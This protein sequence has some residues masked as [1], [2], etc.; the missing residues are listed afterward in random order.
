MSGI[1]IVIP[2]LNEEE[3][4]RELVERLGAALVERVLPYEVIVIDDHSRDATRDVL[5]DISQRYPITVYLKRGQRGKAQSLLEGFAYATHDVVAIL[6]ADLQYPP[7]AIPDMV[8]KLR[9]GYDIV[10]ANRRVYRDFLGRKLVSKI[11]AFFVRT[12]HGFDCDV[13][14]G[15]KVFR[16]KILSEMTLRPT[17]WTFDLEFL[18]K[19]RNNGYVIGNVDIV[20]ENRRAGISKVHFLGTAAEIGMNTLALWFKRHRPFHI[21]PEE[22]S[23]MIG[24]G[25]AYR[26]RRFVTHTTLT[27]DASALQ[28]LVA[29]QK[30][31]LAALLGGATVGFLV[32][33][34][35]TAVIFVG[36]LSAIYFFDMLFNLFLVR[37]SLMASPDIHITPKELS[38]IDEDFLPVYS[39]LCPLYKEA[40]VLPQFRKAIEKLDWPKDKLD[41]LL[42]L[43]EDDAETLA[44][45]HAAEWPTYVR[46]IIV[47]HSFPKT[48]PKAC[49][50]GLALLARGTY[51][52]IYDAEDIPEPLQ[53]KKAYL[54]FQRVPENVRC[55][56]A[57]LNYYN[58]KQNL[59]TKLFAAEYALW[60]DVML[61]GMH[62]M[63]TAI[64]LGG[65]S[66]HFRVEDLRALE[67]W[68]PFNVTEDCDLGARLFRRGYRTAVIDS[69]TLE[70][71]NSR[72][73]SWLKQRSRWL[74]GYIQTY[75]VHMRNPVAFVRAHGAHALAFQ[76]IV[77]GKVAFM[78]INPLLWLA[79][80]AYFALN[81]FVG[82][83]IEALYPGP[84]FGMAVTSLVFGN[85]LHLYY[86]MIGCARRGQW[87][88]IKYVFL[89]PFYWL[90]ASLGAYLAVV[91]LLFKPHYWEKTRHGL[92]LPSPEPAERKRTEK[93]PFPHGRP[94]AP[95]AAP[96][97]GLLA[98]GGILV[99]AML[100]ANF[101][102]FVFN[103]FLGRVLGFEDLG[104]VTLVNTLWYIAALFF[105][106]L[107]VTVN[108]RSA[109]LATSVNT[110]ASAAFWRSASRKATGV[111]LGLTVA[112]IAAVPFL[113][114]FFHIAERMVLLSFTPVITFG[115]L[116]SAN[117]GF[118]HGNLRF[119][120]VAV[121]FLA[122]ALSKLVTAIVLV[123]LG[124][125][126]AVY[127]SIPISIAAAFVVS[128]W[129]T[130]RSNVETTVT[131]DGGRFPRR[132]F[133]ASLL[134]SAS[135][136]AFL[137]VDIALVKHFLSPEAAGQ[138][139]LLSL[140][141]KM[142]YFLGALPAGF[143]LTFVGREEGQQRNPER[144]FAV[145][146]ASTLLLTAIGLFFLGSLGPAL[147]PILLGSKTH[148]ILPYLT[149]YA[150]AIAL[151]TLSN[152]IVVYQLARKR[153]TFPALAGVWSACT[154]L[155]IILHH[156]NLASI[157][158]V[159]FLTS[160]FGFLSLLLLHV[161][162][163]FR[164]AVGGRR[165]DP[166]GTFL[167]HQE[168]VPASVTG[169]RILIFNWRDMRHAFAGGAEIY[170]QDMATRWVRQGHH[171]TLFCGNDRQS[172]RY[173]IVDGVEVIRRGGFYLVYAW[174]FLTY[175]FR[176]R[177]KYDVIVDCCNGIPFFTPLY[178]REPVLCLMYHVHQE[179]FRRSLAAPLAALAR[180]L[181]NGLMPLVY[182]NTPFIT[183]SE[184]SKRDIRALGL[185]RAGIDIVTPG[186]DLGRL[187]SGRKSR[188][189]LVLYVGRLKAYKSV[190]VLLRAFRILLDRVPD[191]QLMVVGSGEEDTSLKRLAREL[192]LGGRVTFTGRV[193]E[194]AKV[195]FLQRAWVLVNPSFMEGWGITTIEA[196]ACGTPVVAANVPGLR[197]SVRNPHTGYL[198]PYGDSRR[199][200]DAIET[201]LQDRA[202]RA[203]M[204]MEA[205]AWAQR[206]GLEQRSQ[207]FLSIITA[208]SSP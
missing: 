94:L 131:T 142:I 66:N 14:A 73:W 154:A 100:L 3:N 43:E 162:T 203:R 107:A 92:H 17:P 115:I 45:V 98:S 30:I 193:S 80:I 195:G 171:V 145:V 141:G 163:T 202:L 158:L 7:E 199:F 37:K 27:H 167:A 119:T 85:F 24:A 140:V 176:F 67:G 46:H 104:L 174:A 64:P 184:S 23:S 69:V 114:E 137:S 106:A 77:G 12:M 33:P 178:A 194:E 50:Y 155:G 83:T 150:V 71:A 60:F 200:A 108:H 201:I 48:K 6:D 63:N 186:V 105:G 59:L 204:E 132:F 133:A 109:Y 143:L 179:V 93:A 47:P 175:L 192:K 68:D 181:E 97:A 51:V 4:I 88:A 177:G 53:L 153:F 20:F 38:A 25:I 70:E 118:L 101:S 78:L 134:A 11:F 147:L 19:A 169:K 146:F 111:A 15:L 22:R 9:E 122:E 165:S 113:S 124:A 81:E 128:V 187:R 65:T 129:M 32:A 74:K 102:N 189:P 91:Q 58:P 40:A 36:L 125:P 1:S 56:Q 120:A 110:E 10:V 75:L 180:F 206:F 116:V 160:V 138:Y 99:G 18:V 121:L 89:A 112:W 13:Q 148:A 82:P 2:T 144:T 123:S 21:H 117:R 57:K 208:Q 31:V 16:R 173:E 84:V 161:H 76:F 49:N 96:A 149:M 191:A 52:V 55:L 205:I 44:A 103:A 156:E 164:L 130:R 87:W 152:A 136:T 54:A 29:W 72:L 86:Y 196:N 5:A 79:T 42:L 188:I 168:L 28:T 198:V 182:R 159:V 190:D 135:A 172:P 151:F 35:P 90:L 157:T 95:T 34:L 166:R 185:G 41:V 8:G 62:A 183:I 39:I 139:A 126:S 207:R 170:I 127:V 197:D 26:R 61:P